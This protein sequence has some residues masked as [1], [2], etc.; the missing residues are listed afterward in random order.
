[1]G[2]RG[3]RRLARLDAWTEGEEEGNQRWEGEGNIARLLGQQYTLNRTTLE[4]NG[5][6]TEKKHGTK[7]PICNVYQL[8]F[9]LCV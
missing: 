7:S 9:N 2:S 4:L 3:L 8:I 1:M 6:W 5:R